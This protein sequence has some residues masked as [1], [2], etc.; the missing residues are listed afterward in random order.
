MKK[1]FGI[2]IITIFVAAPMVAGAA[3]AKVP[4]VNGGQTPESNK[5]VASTSYVQGAYNQLGKAVN[6]IITD[7]TVPTNENGYKA[8][9]ADKNVAE[10]LVALD[11]AIRDAAGEAGDLYVTKESARVVVDTTGGATGV[12]YVSTGDGK[13]GENLGILDNQVYKHS[14]KIGEFN[15]SGNKNYV[16]GTNTIQQ[17]IQILDGRVKLNSDTIGSYDEDKSHVVINGASSIF[18]NLHALDEQVTASSLSIDQNTA[19]I[20]TMIN[21]VPAGIS[22][23][24]LVDAVISVKNSLNTSNEQAAISNG[25]YIGSDHGV[26]TVSGALTALDG[27]TKTNSDNIATMRAQKMNVMTTWGSDSTVEREVFP[28]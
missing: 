4:L 22:A 18:D 24:N 10:N 8:I 21:L 15:D 27:Q 7:S 23:T 9:A 28:Q 12:Q 6:S 14:L 16:S 26:T 1:L 5:V 3:T 19:A 25:N 17:N 13:V 20:G 2:S 11:G